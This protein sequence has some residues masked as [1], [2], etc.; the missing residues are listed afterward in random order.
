VTGHRSNGGNA[1]IGASISSASA[2][3]ASDYRVLYSG[4]TYTVTRLSDNTSQSFAGLPQTVDG[5]TLQ[6]NAGAPSDG[7]SFLIQPTV[8]AARDFNL[9]FRDPALIAAA[10]PIR[11]GSSS[12]NVG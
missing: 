10:A 2:L 5:I 9:A 3:T 7:D 4:G 1:D 11:T 12:A 8:N 6:L